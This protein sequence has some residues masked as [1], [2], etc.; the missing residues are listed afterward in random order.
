MAR[1]DVKAEI[2]VR[3]G[4]N[5]AYLYLF[6]LLYVDRFLI[7]SV[8]LLERKGLLRELVAWSERVRWTDYQSEHGI[9]MWRKACQPSNRNPAR[10]HARQRGCLHSSLVS[11]RP[12]ASQNTSSPRR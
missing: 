1:K 9:S 7:T 2:Q 8:P 3:M 10:L 5:P 4:A 6:D 11:R 12:S